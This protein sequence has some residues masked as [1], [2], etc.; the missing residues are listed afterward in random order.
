MP[1]PVVAIDVTT[2]INSLE[3]TQ[4]SVLAFDSLTQSLGAKKIKRAS[5]W[6]FFSLLFYRKAHFK[7]VLFGEKIDFFYFAMLPSFTSL[8]ESSYSEY[9]QVAKFP[10]FSEKWNCLSQTHIEQ[11]LTEIIRMIN[12]FAFYC[13]HLTSWKTAEC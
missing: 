10:I 2:E 8:V 5:C 6:A 12:K 9:L 7:Y 1:P 4:S 11:S 13:T 3:N